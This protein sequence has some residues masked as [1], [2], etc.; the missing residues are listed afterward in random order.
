ML[1]AAEVGSNLAG[2]FRISALR[3]LRRMRSEHVPDT[4]SG[5]QFSALVCLSR[6]GAL[7]PRELGI[8]EQIQK[9]TVTKLIAALEANGLISRRGDP[10][11]RRRLILELTPADE[12]RAI[13]GAA[14][15]I[16]NKIVGD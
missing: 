13:L 14:I 12:E 16:I 15:P 2:Q 6:H 3:L 4:P 7:T 10:R 1:S 11:D 9:S 8:Y 5:V